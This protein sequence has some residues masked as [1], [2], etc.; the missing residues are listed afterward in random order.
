M[1]A[2][3]RFVSDGLALEEGV[4]V[5]AAPQRRRRLRE[6]L[7]HAGF[8]VSH[9]QLANLVLFL[10]A[11]ETLK[12]FMVN[13]WPDRQRFSATIA[14]AVGRVAAPG[15]KV[16]A[17]GEMVVLLWES[18]AYEATVRLEYLWD[19]FCAGNRLTLLCGYPESALRTGPTCLVE[20]IHRAH[21][22]V[23]HSGAD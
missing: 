23:F 10:D 16:R 11:A 14:D 5:I 9:P 18:R 12:R 3:T 20:G 13:G 15:R 6:C 21:S 7:R 4:I 2:L 22:L 19:E 1:D 17:F 8:D